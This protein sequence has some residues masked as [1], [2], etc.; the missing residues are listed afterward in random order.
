MPMQPQRPQKS[1][2]SRTGAQSGYTAQ[3]PRG[4]YRDEASGQNPYTS[5]PHR[6]PLSPAERRRRRILQKKRRRRRIVRLVCTAAACLLL[7]TALIFTCVFAVRMLSEE[8]APAGSFDS[9][10]NSGHDTAD[11][12]ADTE[13]ALPEYDA[14][15]KVEGIPIRPILTETVRY[16]DTEISC[17]HAILVNVEDGQIVAGKNITD[18]IYPASMTKLMTVLVAYENITDINAVFRMTNE[19]IDPLYLDG[20]S[21]AGFSGG[22]DVVIRDLLYGSALPSGAEASVAL[23]IAACGSEDAFVARMNERAASLGMTG[24]NFVNCTGAHHP[25]H[26]STLSDIAILTAFIMQN[27]ELAEIFGTYQHTTVPTAK[28][29]EGILLTST[30]FSRMEGGESGVCTVLGG[31]TGYTVQG[32]QCLATYAKHTVT[33]H[34]YVCVMAG[35]ETK[36]RP[37]YDTIHLYQ[38]YT[39]STAAPSPDEAESTS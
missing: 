38:Y 29:P 24:T 34:R 12:E 2:T 23:A 9:E 3:P 31:K 36:W 33:G 28:H 15:R 22:E 10:Q 16:P 6:P 25:D 7:L 26:V 14:P 17:P 1:Q 39:A 19:I 4:T 5:V 11:T 30:V 32:G 18:S 21:L 37:V 35:G 20:L 27:D 13:P 8:H